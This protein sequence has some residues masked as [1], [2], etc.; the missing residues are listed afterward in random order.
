[1]SASIPSSPP[2]QRISL[3][4]ILSPM[5]LRQLLAAFMILVSLSAQARTELACGMSPAVAVTHDCCPPQAAAS[6]DSGMD[7]MPGCEHVVPSD[8]PLAQASTLA[9]GALHGLSPDTVFPPFPSAT[10]QSLIATS[11]E[12]DRRNSATDGAD[13]GRRKLRPLYLQTARLRL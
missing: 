7:S 8:A 6:G 2:L 5:S 3:Q 1:M 10:I 11:I 4:A 12:I 13:D 9:D